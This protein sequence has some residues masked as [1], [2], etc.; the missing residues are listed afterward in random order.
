MNRHIHFNW[1]KCF[2]PLSVTASYVHLLWLILVIT[3]MI[4]LKK[5]SGELYDRMKMCQNTASSKKLFGLKFN[6]LIIKRYCRF[7]PW[8]IN[9]KVSG[10]R[11]I[12]WKQCRAWLYYARSGNR[13]IKLITSELEVVCFAVRNMCTSLISTSSH[14]IHQFV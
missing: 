7:L 6:R 14:L 8:L 3:L 9:N 5:K 10:F 1:T 11:I 13:C 12:G 2:K 4:L